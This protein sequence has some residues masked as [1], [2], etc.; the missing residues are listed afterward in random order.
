MAV[1]APL[2]ERPA[3]RPGDP[4]PSRRRA[5]LAARILSGAIAGT[6]ILFAL[7]PTGCYLSRAG[8]E[9]ARILGRRRAIASILR[10]SAVDASTRAKLRLVLEA[11]DYA[12]HSLGLDVGESF[13]TFSPLDR[14]TLVLVVSAA[15]RDRLEPYTWWFP[16]VGRVPY[17]GFFDFGSARELAARLGREGF[18]VYMR[19]ASAFSTLGWFNDP[20]LSTTLRADSLDLV[21]TVIHEVTHNS[22]YGSGEAVFNESFANFVG[23]RGAEAFFRARGDTASAHETVR[24]WEDEKLLAAFWTRLYGTLDSAYAAH[25]DDR[26]ARLVARD[27]VYARAR[28]ALISEI[29]PRLRTMPVRYAER[30]ALDNAAL[31]ARRIYLTDLELF[32]RVYRREGESLRRAVDRIIGLAKGA[33]GDPFA[34]V[35]RWLGSTPGGR[36]ASSGA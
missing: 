35:T 1:V 34:A 33:K 23:A 26:D 3:P 28:R 15:H 31:L 29:G 4:P 18:D 19:P 20:L 6:A 21:N 11:R 27:T 17:K 8:W 36:D 12:R 13:T 5:R 30:V 25:P 22:Y 2:S 14:D 16:I 9:E 32:D 7:T 24:R 10:D